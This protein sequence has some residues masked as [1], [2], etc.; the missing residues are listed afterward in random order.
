MAQLGPTPAHPSIHG[1]QFGSLVNEFYALFCIQKTE[2]KTS[3]RS[4]LKW[5]LVDP[6]AG[7]RGEVI[8]LSNPLK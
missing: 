1:L 7:Y 2:L 5:N 6:S 8:H 4:D 3:K